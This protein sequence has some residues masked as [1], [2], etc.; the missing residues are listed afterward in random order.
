VVAAVSVAIE[1]Q[2]R[3]AAQEFAGRRLR[4][5][6][7]VHYGDVL[8]REG[9]AHGDA[10]NVAARLQSIARPGTICIS[11]GVYRHVRHRFDEPIQDLGLQ[12]LKNISEPVHAYLII[13]RGLEDTAG[14]RLRPLGTWAAGA[15][16]LAAAVVAA[17]LGWRHWTRP[18]VAP[19][20]LSL[21]TG[22]TVP[23][24]VLPAGD[25]TEQITLGVMLFK[26]LGQDEETAWMREALRDGLNTQLSELKR[27]KVYS[28]EFIDFVTT[29]EGLT[30]IEA[31][32]K[33]G[34]AKMLSGSF[35]AVGDVLRIEIHIVD[36][37]SGV[38]ESS[39]TTTGQQQ[40]FLALEDR[41]VGDVMTRLGLPI[42][43]EERAGLLAKRSTDPEAVRHLLEVEGKGSAGSPRGPDS[44]LQRW[45][46]SRRLA[47]TAL[48]EQPPD[49]TR[50]EILAVLER[51]RRATEG[52]EMQA[53]AGIYEEFTPEQQAAQQRY[54]DGVRDLRIAFDNI[55]VAVVGD[56][57]VVS[58]TRT[59]EF[60]DART[61]RPMRASVRLTK[62]LRRET[63]G[64]KLAQGK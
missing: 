6:I 50:A 44:M 23:A 11:D 59:D 55:D 29:R 13:P 3:I 37:P 19:R 21:A 47:G 60:T 7:G 9:T 36:V 26:P 8:L 34:I 17:G 30:E 41:M 20:T 24:A 52:R 51:Y 25:Q 43:D 48:A 22:V 53:L 49:A 45:L 12:R 63:G 35:V 46:A 33:L 14:G 16:L 10:I 1:I 38:L 39:V 32:T 64:W 18:V 54:F 4:M 58:Y 61:G 28:K 27:V 31:A 42:S 5:R 56:E 40:E 62:V 2:Q 15:A 57:A